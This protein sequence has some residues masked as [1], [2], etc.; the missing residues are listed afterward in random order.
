MNIPKFTFKLPDP[1]IPPEV[2][3][4]FKEYIKRQNAM[5]F[6]P[7]YADPIAPAMSFKKFIEVWG[8]NRKRGNTTPE[9]IYRK[10]KEKGWLEKLYD[11]YLK[12]E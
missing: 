2:P 9:N 6:L 5:L 8:K 12:D 7:M 3:E 1:Q 11:E 4:E 10:P